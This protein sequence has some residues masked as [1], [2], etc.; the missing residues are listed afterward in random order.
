MAGFT[1][2][3]QVFVP[4]YPG[5][6]STFTEHTGNDARVSPQ[7]SAKDKKLR[8]VLDVGEYQFWLSEPIAWAGT[9][10]GDQ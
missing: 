6:N 8:S 5:F 2:R 4:R 10:N 9:L 7:I 1:L 3:H